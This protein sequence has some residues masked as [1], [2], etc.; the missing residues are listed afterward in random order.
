MHVYVVQS[1]LSLDIIALITTSLS[2]LIVQGR[3]PCQ[4]NLNK[5]SVSH[6]FV[7]VSRVFCL[8]LNDL[9]WGLEKCV[10]I[11]LIDLLHILQYFNKQTNAAY[12]M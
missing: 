11:L 9:I 7:N 12:S 5:I 1:W 4:T 3:G 8:F 10:D 6:I 2:A